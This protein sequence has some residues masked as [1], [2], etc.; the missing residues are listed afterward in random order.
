MIKTLMHKLIFNAEFGALFHG[1]PKVKLNGNIT[2]NSTFD[3]DLKKEKSQ[4]QDS[5][6]KF[7]IYPV[8]S[9]GLLYKF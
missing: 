2:E 6:D 8:I 4:L 5:L 3:A 9:L 1:K 7:Y